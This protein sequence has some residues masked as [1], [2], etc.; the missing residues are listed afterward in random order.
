MSGQINRLRSRVVSDQKQDVL[1]PREVQG[2]IVY[3]DESVH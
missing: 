2:E 1:P 3:D